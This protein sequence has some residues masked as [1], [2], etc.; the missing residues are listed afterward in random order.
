MALPI[1]HQNLRVCRFGDASGVDFG[2]CTLPL[3][4]GLRS[5]ATAQ[6]VAT[7][8]SE[9]STRSHQLAAGCTV[10]NR[11]NPPVAPRSLIHLN[12]VDASK[13]RLLWTV[14]KLSAG[15]GETT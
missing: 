14:I 1:C 5:T 12:D 4:E 15:L 8:R 10:G 6:A 9:P 13:L 11:Y 2:Y 3:W 7:Q